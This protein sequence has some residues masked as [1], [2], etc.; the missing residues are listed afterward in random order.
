MAPN[1]SQRLPTAAYDYKHTLLLFSSSMTPTDFHLLT[2]RELTPQ[3]YSQPVAL[4]GRSAATRLAPRATGRRRSPWCTGR[5]CG[6]RLL[7]GWGRHRG[8][9]RA[10]QGTSTN[11]CGSI[12]PRLR[13]DE[14]TICPRPKGARWRPRVPEG[15]GR[16]GWLIR[17]I[18][19]VGDGPSNPWDG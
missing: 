2:P 16:D 3:P 5:L 19:E 1:G 6:V 12:R 18:A 13:S 9:G 14:P 8:G 15:R 17:P 10:P 4:N 7:E 11:M